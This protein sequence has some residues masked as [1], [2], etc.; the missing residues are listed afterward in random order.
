MFFACR[1]ATNLQPDV[2]ELVAL[3]SLFQI[4][5]PLKSLQF[6]CS[7]NNDER[8]TSGN[9]TTSDDQLETFGAEETP[10]AQLILTASR[11]AAHHLLT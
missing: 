6:F 5:K 3:S 9:F 4:L 11:D 7:T 8:P 2:D 10:S 1:L